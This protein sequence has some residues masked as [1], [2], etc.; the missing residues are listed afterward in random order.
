MPNYKFPPQTTTAETLQHFQ[1]HLITTT[2]DGLLASSRKK[3][4]LMVENLYLY[5]IESEN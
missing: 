4:T 1:I 5:K 3:A 2:S